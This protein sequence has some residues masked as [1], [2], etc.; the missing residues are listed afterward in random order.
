[1]IQLLKD[2][3][4]NIVGFRAFGNVTEQDYKSVIIPAVEDLVIK[5]NAINCLLL[6][7]TDVA[8]IKFGTWFMDALLRLPKIAKWHH[9]AIISDSEA[10][11]RFRHL[12]K[13]FTRGELKFFPKVEQ[14]KA[15]QWAASGN[16][17]TL[18]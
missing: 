14:E 6:L 10:V 2:L 16:P 5:K 7:D 8:T 12:F 3:P 9:F 15:I 18:L 11:K 13:F 1:M 17:D 4:Q